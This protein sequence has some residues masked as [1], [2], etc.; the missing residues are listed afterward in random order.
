[1]ARAPLL[2]VEEALA[3]ILTDVRPTAAEPC[4]ISAC[5]GR[6]LAEDVASRRTQP[7]FP[8]SAM[9]GYAVRGADV[10]QP[11]ARLKVIGSSAAGHGFAGR[12]GAGEAVRIFTGAPV[13]AGADTILIQE[14]ASLS[15]D[16]VTALQAEPTGRF[17]RPEGMDFRTGEVL[18]KAGTRLGAREIALAAA[19]NHAALP[20]RRRP[21]VAILATGDELV[22]PGAEPGPDQI[23]ASNNI[24]VATAVESAG[25]QPLLLGIARD[26]AESLAESIASARASGAD[27][28]VTIGGAS[29]GDH[30]LV[31][32]ALAREGMSLSF[33]RIAMRPGKPLMFGALDGMRILGLPG[34]PVAS[35]VC[36]LIFLQ[37]LI[38][39]LL[40]TAAPL[41]AATRPALLGMDVGANDER[42]DYLRVRISGESQ[43]LPVVAPHAR[44]DSAMLSTLAASD[45]LLIRAPHAPAAR[46]GAPCTILPLALLDS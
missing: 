40:A 17:V 44:Q 15:N 33:W 41:E 27:V 9:D 2:P 30:D 23:V 43:G 38:R 37:P 3:R 26:S 4:P 16:V 8:S 19:M 39:A 14:N 10:S 21:M 45:A 13:P 7:P 5:R 12:V 42:Q 11:G 1:M 6:I 32:A 36:T 22:L 35:I 20:V 31:Q 24:A 28:L 29:V 46:S 25:G 34:N 18:L